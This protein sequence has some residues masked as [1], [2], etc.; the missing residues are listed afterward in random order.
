MTSHSSSSKRS[1]LLHSECCFFTRSSG[2][3][4]N[5]LWLAA[6]SRR[7]ACF[8]K[9]NIPK[10]L[11]LIFHLPSAWVNALLPSNKEKSPNTRLNVSFHCRRKLH[12]ACAIICSTQGV[13][14]GA[15]KPGIHSAWIRR[16]GF[17]A[18]RWQRE[19]LGCRASQLA[20]FI[21]HVKKRL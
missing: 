11:P 17:L 9:H 19:L 8:G 20:H 12:R 14:L 13:D 1:I 5:L 3:L 16:L 6:D 7:H 4:C 21:P 2:S 18:V 15:A 10:R